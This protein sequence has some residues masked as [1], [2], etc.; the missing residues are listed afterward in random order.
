MLVSLVLIGCAGIPSESTERT[1]TPN[2]T[3][4]EVVWVDLVEREVVVRLDR[5]VDLTGESL[6]IS[7]DESLQ[8]SAV[9][10]PHPEREGRTQAFTLLYGYPRPGHDVTVPDAET[11]AMLRNQW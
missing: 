10:E 8:L 7:R 9:L 4:G 6:V 3:L 2:E 1:V 5:D 11:R